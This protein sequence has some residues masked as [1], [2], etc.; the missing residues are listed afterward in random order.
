[1]R[2]T[3]I[4]VLLISLTAHAGSVQPPTGPMPDK[5]MQ[6]YSQEWCWLV[7][8]DA[9]YIVKWSSQGKP[10]MDLY[11]GAMMDRK[12]S[13]NRK[14]S[15]VYMIGDFQTSIQTWVTNLKI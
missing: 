12:L 14:K 3:F 4:L 7:G 13:I 2:I 11:R 6:F 10:V 15:I 5:N 9:R 8:I 1:M